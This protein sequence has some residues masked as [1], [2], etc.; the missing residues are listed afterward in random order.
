M[1]TNGIEISRSHNNNFSRVYLGEKITLWF[2]Y[3][4]IVAFAISGEGTFK[5]RK[6]RYS[7][8][9]AKHLASVPAQELSD[10]DFDARIAELLSRLSA[11]LG[12]VNVTTAGAV[13]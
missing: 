13:R 3:E 2:S 8:T 7:V 4:T 11:A 10:E 9:T 1:P 6:M 12:S 5:T